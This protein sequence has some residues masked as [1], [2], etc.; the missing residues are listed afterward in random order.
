MAG[1][2]SVR[3]HDGETPDQQ[4]KYFV[5]LEWSVDKVTGIRAL[6]SPAMR[7]TEPTSDS[8]E[9][10]Q[11]DSLGS[12]QLKVKTAQSTASAIEAPAA[13]PETNMRGMALRSPR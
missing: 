3:G 8:A 4:A 12:G 13:R 2:A 5:L 11:A 6:T 1:R 10:D 7:S 9:T